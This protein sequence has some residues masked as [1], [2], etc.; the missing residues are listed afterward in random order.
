M[1]NQAK[2]AIKILADSAAFA[3]EFSNRSNRLN[4]LFCSICLGAK[5]K[6]DLISLED[7]RIIL[8]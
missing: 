3:V 4:I 7:I 8:I 6:M 1:R 5:Y 2:T